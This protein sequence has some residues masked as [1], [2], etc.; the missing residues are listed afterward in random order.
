M[1]DKATANVNYATDKT[2]Q[3]G[4]RVFIARGNTTVITIAY[5]LF[6]IANY[7]YILILNFGKVVK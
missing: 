3:R 7:S 5:R 4:L 6:I 2:I 1:F